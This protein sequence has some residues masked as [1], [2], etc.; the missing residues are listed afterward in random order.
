MLERRSAIHARAR[1]IVEESGALWAVAVDQAKAEDARARQI[2][3]ESGTPWAAAVEEAKVAISAESADEP[4]SVEQSD[5]VGGRPRSSAAVVGCFI[6]PIAAIGVLG[7]LLAAVVVSDNAGEVRT[8]YAD[9]ARPGLVIASDT[10]ADFGLEVVA[11]E[12][13]PSTAQLERDESCDCYRVSLGKVLLT[14]ID[15]EYYRAVNA[16]GRAVSAAGYG[17]LDDA[18]EL[19]TRRSIRFR[20]FPTSWR[21]YMEATDVYWDGDHLEAQWLDVYA[22]GSILGAFETA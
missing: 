10:L 17:T 12:E 9:V 2:V 16:V 14:P 15:G 21:L 13:L 18:A 20:S 4:S 11:A 7:L 22:T 3:E 19:H 1:E 5:R 8:V 6:A